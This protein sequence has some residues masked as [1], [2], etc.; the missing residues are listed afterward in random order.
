ESVLYA[1][2]YE[3]TFDIVGAFSTGNP[4]PGASAISHP[5]THR[6]PAERRP[7][8]PAWPQRPLRSLHLRQC[9]FGL[10]QPE[11]HVH[12][13][14][15]VDGGGQGGAGLLPMASRSV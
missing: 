15:E 1:R 2:I 11:G 12:G 3:H 5:M 4:F 9:G 13:A 7:P 14:V 8:L 10:G 6:S